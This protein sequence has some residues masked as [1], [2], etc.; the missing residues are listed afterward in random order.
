MKNKKV[1]KRYIGK[2][3][4]FFVVGAFIMTGIRYLTYGGLSLGSQVNNEEFTKYAATVDDILIPENV[5]IIALGEATHGNKEF[6]RLKLTVFKK[7]IEEYNC[8]T[9]ALE[10][11]Y[12]GCLK[13]N[14]YIH[15]KGGVTEDEA[16]KALSFHL[17]QT[18]EM[19]ELIRYMADYNKQAEPEDKL[20]FYGFD[21]QN[22]DLD[23]NVVD[24][25]F[26]DL[27]LQ[28]NTMK[29]A[30]EILRKI[31]GM[32]MYA[33]AARCC[34]QN[35]KLGKTSDEDYGKVRDD[36]MA[37]NISWIYD[38]AQEVESSRIMIAGHNGHVAKK[39]SLMTYMG[40][41]LFKK[42]GEDYYVI[43]TDFY[44]TN[45]NL[46]GKNGKRIIRTFYSTDPLANTANAL[47]MD[48]VYLDFD[49]LQE[50]K[51]LSETINHKML[52]GSLGENYSILN[53][54]LP[55]SYRVND[56]PAKLYDGMIIVTNAAP[57]EIKE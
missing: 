8:K 55:Y 38:H 27:E 50:S 48:M 14:E 41:D 18:D 31:P 40:E 13:V 23:K 10:A 43:G 29:E 34:L 37:E 1:K 36:Y 4:A 15:G 56:V 28:Y 3:I 24:K 19:R 7:M 51:K 22:Y 20:S 2:M 44:K 33:Q 57:T 46:P 39:S 54:I 11:D 21:M 30:E 42:Y 53:K 26:E 9:F 47:D 35:Q 17:Y 12:G 25:A 32:D 49:K 45:C 5:K 52:M 16:L 6:Q